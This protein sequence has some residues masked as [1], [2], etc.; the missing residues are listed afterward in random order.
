MRNMSFALTT[1]QICARSK[2]VTRR[3]GW[4]NLRPGEKFRAVVKGQGL[5]KGERVERLCVLECVSNRSVVLN[6]ITKMDVVLEGFPHMTPDEFVDMFCKHN[7][8]DPLCCV[9]RI[10]FRYV[11]YVCMHADACG[12]DPDCPHREPHGAVECEEDDGRHSCGQSLGCKEVPYG[13]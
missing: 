11:D 7:G 13:G 1:G 12:F 10:A 2:H 3:L 9:N 8:C 6:S 5:K 4:D